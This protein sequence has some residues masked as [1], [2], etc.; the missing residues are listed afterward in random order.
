MEFILK[1]LTIGLALLLFKISINKGKMLAPSSLFTIFWTGQ[2]LFMVIGWSTY[3]QFYYTG[4]LYILFC[5]VCFRFGFN[6]TRNGCNADSNNYQIVSTVNMNRVKQVLF[7]LLVL[8]FYNSISSLLAYGLNFSTMFDINQMAVMSNEMSVDRYSG[9]G[10]GRGIVTRLI[11]LNAIVCPLF[12]GYVYNMLNEKKYFAFLPFFPMILS[13]LSHGAKMGMITGTF[14]WLIGFILYVQSYRL[15]IKIRFIYI[16]RIVLMIVAFFCFLLLSMM[17]RIGTVDA[18]TFTVVTGKFNSYFFGHLP[19]FD[20]WFNEHALDD[21][22][23]TFGGKLFYGITNSLGLME[24]QSGIFTELVKISKGGDYTNVF[25]IFR[26]LI[27]D[28]GVIFTPLFLII[29]GVII[30]NIYTEYLKGVNMPFY[31]SIMFMVYFFISWSFV[32]SVFAYGTYLVL[33]FYFY[34]ILK[35][36]NVRSYK[37]SIQ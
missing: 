31:T 7:V 34:F 36:I 23:L 19:A 29:C 1:L 6:I 33:P 24:R 28:F 16:L 26:F 4:L 13:G 20:W 32:A 18:E 25:T 30:R 37:Y 17:M 11:G 9:G 22:A 8:S 14:M 10:E 35:Y 5:L 12:G 15:T 27:E 2:I 3:L 21:R